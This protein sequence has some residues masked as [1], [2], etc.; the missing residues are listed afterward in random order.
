MTDEREM[1]LDVDGRQAEKKMIE[2]QF[3]SYLEEIVDRIVYTQDESAKTN[4]ICCPRHYKQSDRADVM[5]HHL[6]EVLKKL[7]LLL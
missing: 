3:H 5:N 1:I 6:S 4:H 7:Q 2:C